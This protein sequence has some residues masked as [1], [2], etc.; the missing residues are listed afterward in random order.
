MLINKLRQIF[1]GTFMFWIVVTHGRII[2]ETF[3][4]LCFHFQEFS[5]LCHSIS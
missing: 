1:L 2:K 3:L 4:K 5:V